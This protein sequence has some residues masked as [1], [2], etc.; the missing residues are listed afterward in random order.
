MRPGSALLTIST[1]LPRSGKHNNRDLVKQ[2]SQASGQS[3]AGFQ[4]TLSNVG[5]ARNLPLF[6][7]AS[8][9]ES[10]VKTQR[11][12]P[13]PR[14]FAVPFFQSF[15]KKKGPQETTSVLQAAGPSVEMHKAAGCNPQST[16]GLGRMCEPG[17]PSS[18]KPSRE[19]FSHLSPLGD[20]FFKCVAQ[21]IAI[22]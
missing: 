19:N 9:W 16:A 22:G 21:Q 18:P 1:R 10:F 20:V 6:D 2:V 13:P 4:F 5:I 3:V 8:R 14:R 11:P 12:Q 15:Q 7:A 17:S